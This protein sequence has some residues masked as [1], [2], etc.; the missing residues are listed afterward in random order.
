MERWEY[1]T[2]TLH[3]DATEDQWNVS[4]WDI[5]ISRG[6]DFGPALNFFGDQGWEAVNLA[7]VSVRLF[8]P[9]VGPQY[10]L[11]ADVYRILFKRRK[12]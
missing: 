7:P 3:F 5:A 10:G 8:S 6:A 2:V 12:P 1:M 4:G 11:Y 9:E